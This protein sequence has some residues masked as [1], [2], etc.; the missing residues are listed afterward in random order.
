MNR[1]T[2]LALTM[3]LLCSGVAMLEGN[4]IGHAQ[5]SDID[6]TKAAHADWHAALDVLDIRK[7]EDA[8]AHD[9]HAT[10]IGPRDKTITM[11]WDAVRK[12][13]EGIVAV[14]SEQKHTTQEGPHIHQNEGIALVHSV[15]ANSGKLKSGAF[16]NPAPTFETLMLERRGDRWLI[17]SA[18]AVRVPQ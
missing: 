14:W 12:K 18:S 10:Y 8:W 4:E 2:T 17:V 6:K 1:R 15:V 3:G 9:A 11:G 7:M 16:P 5:Q 13:L